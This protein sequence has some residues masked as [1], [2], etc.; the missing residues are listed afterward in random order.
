MTTKTVPIVPLGEMTDGQ[1]ADVFVLM[2]SK[3]EATT[4]NGKP[5][6][7]VGFRDAHRE[8]NFPI[9]GD[10]IW[11]E[12]C[13]EQWTPG[14]FYKVRAI[15]KES[16]YGPQLDIKNIRTATSEDAADGFDEMMCRPQTQFDSEQM[17]AEMLSIAK[18]EIVD[19]ELAA[20]TVEILENHRETLCTL[21]AATYN[22]H[23]FAGGYMEHV[24]SVT[25]N[26]RLL[27]DK[28][29]AEYPDMR[30][31]L[32][33]DLVLAG[34]ILH[35]IGKLEELQQTPAGAEYTP[36]GELIGHILLGR[37]IVR[38]AAATHDIDRETLLRLEHIII[39]HQRLPEWGSPKQPMMPEALIVHYA[40]DLDAK[41]QM[42]YAALRDEPGEGPMTTQKN[43][44][45]HKVFR[46]LS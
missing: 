44:L 46:G 1:E 41:F 27:V 8:V 16:T 20:L 30:P 43:P 13:S 4:K 2:T 9:W 25:K 10:T 34:A 17:F 31:P 23:A 40:D 38:D 32:S 15:Y 36:Q 42:M 24:L 35:D 14:Q 28:Y 21:P 12:P 39:S 18:E 45:R 3:D 6:W 11:A 19:G 29:C 22:H 37:D 5:Y 7:R 26:A 33:R